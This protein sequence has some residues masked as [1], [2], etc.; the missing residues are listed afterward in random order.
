MRK[1]APVAVYCLLGLYIA[2]SLAYQIVGSVAVIVGFFDLRH[3][4][5]EPFQ[6]DWYR[7]VVTSMSSEAASAG[8]RKGDTV[9]TIDGMPLRGRALIQAARWY[10]HPGGQT[11]LGVVRPDNSRATISIPLHGYKVHPGIGES[12][13][14][15]FLHVAVPLFSL[16]IGYWVVLAR[17]T[18]PN[19][20]LILVLLSLPESFISVSTYNAWPGPWLVLR[21]GWHLVL[22]IMTPAVLLWFGLVFPE[23]SR[24]DMRVP[25]LKWLALTVQAGGLAWELLSDYEV[26]YNLKFFPQ[27]QTFE[28]FVSRALEWTMLLWI[29]LYWVAIFSNLRSATNA[30][31]VRRLRV[32][33]A[34]S[35]LGLGSTLVIWGLLPHFGVDPAS[36]QWLGYVSA[37]LLL[38]FPLSLAYVVIVQRA[39]DVRILMRM[40]TRYLLARAT[41]AVLQ[42]AA[43]G[44]LLFAY[45]V[46]VLRRHESRAEYV[47]IPT[48]LVVIFIRIN[49]VKRSPGD[50]LREWLDRRFFREAYQA[51]L[52]LSELTD[53]IRTISEPSILI[54]TVRNR[55]S[56]VL[57]VPR[58][59]VLLRN[60][61]VFR[62][63]ALALAETSA[64]VQ[65]LAKTNSPAVLYRDRPEDWF[66][67]SSDHDQQALDAVRAEVLLPF[68]GREKLMGVMLLGP[69]LSEEPFSP[70]DLRLL[71]SIGIQAGISLEIGEMAQS[72]AREMSRSERIQR[73]I[74]IAREVQERLFPQRIPQL[75]GVELAG[76]CRPALGVGGDYYDMIELE[77][78]R[79]A[80]AIGDVSGK[81]I[82]AALLMASLRASL[83]G[84][85]DVDST[86]LARVVS[87]LNRLVYESSTSNRYATFFLAIYD[88]ATH[89]LHYVNGGHNAP[90]V[91]RASGE[92]VRLEACG[93]VV[94]LLPA[95]QFEERVEILQPG[96]IFIGYTD[97]ISE[98]MTSDDEEWGEDRMIEAASASRELCPKQLLE[99]LMAGAD[100]F[101][102]GAPQHDDM[103]LVVGRFA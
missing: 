89:A 40:G 17:P 35:V 21:L 25:W 31:T 11:V 12:V 92:V 99:A 74:E 18:D 38:I 20:W 54:E 48:F 96:D 47:L 63:G 24:I 46:P 75:A 30:D 64:P 68:P 93:P 70:T 32:L 3:Q 100:G 23:R 97:G 67:H 53:Q 55:V 37:I 72:L 51:E 41:F 83:H 61:D 60:A 45:V 82:G 90:V 56:E 19:A 98:A 77:G 26:W 14:I 95:V 9:E 27:S 34:G 36:R 6:T 43:I 71:A 57:H 88:H 10:A 33:C 44:F 5:E 52:V 62:G 80:I 84:L 16:L 58:T 78:G 49:F 76:H 91:L 79:L 101:T 28:P 1:R 8:L 29:G 94:G 15:L 13:F 7:P 22:N 103:T 73:E 65:H 42:I 2:I 81:G 66:I 50:R 69:K 59:A 39:L 87:K 102:A 86:G 4:V 85:L